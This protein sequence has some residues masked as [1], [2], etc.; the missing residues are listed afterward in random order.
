MVAAAIWLLIGFFTETNQDD[1][2]VVGDVQ[3]EFPVA[4]IRATEEIEEVKIDLPESVSGFSVHHDG[5]RGKSYLWYEGEKV[6]EQPLSD[7]YEVKIGA[8]FSDGSP[9]K[10][11]YTLHVHEQEDYFD[12]Y[13]VA[14]I[15]CGGCSWFQDWFLRFDRS[16]DSFELVELDVDSLPVFLKAGMNSFSLLSPDHNQMAM[17][18]IVY[19]CSHNEGV[20]DMLQEPCLLVSEEVWIYDFR[21]HEELLFY[22][23]PDGVTIRDTFYGWPMFSDEAVYWDEN[24]GQLVI[25]PVSEN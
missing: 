22:T 7:L 16:V 10:D 5:D 1:S 12:V 8:E 13:L 23:T 18:N 25:S 21:T 24:T 6:F 20:D 2:L 3:I 4:E 14:G 15:G 17:P 9:D 11:F 19:D